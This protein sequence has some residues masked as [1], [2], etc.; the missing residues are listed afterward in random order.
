MPNI[1]FRDIF[2]A[3]DGSLY[4]WADSFGSANRIIHMDSEGTILSRSVGM[5]Y[6]IVYFGGSYARRYQTAFDGNYFYGIG[7][8][9]LDPYYYFMKFDTAGRRMFNIPL[10]EFIP[11]AGYIDYSFCYLTRD[12][13]ILIGGDYQD[14]A[15]AWSSPF[16]L[17]CSTE[18]ELL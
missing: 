18:G 17:A 5:P 3:P 2:P 14:T 13:T 16:L 6:W 1:E 10:Q 9:G 15:T 8:D 4:A 7:N 12:H 11:G